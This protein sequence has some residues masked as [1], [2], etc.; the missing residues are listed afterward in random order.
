MCE[1]VKESLLSCVI[2]YLQSISVRW[3]FLS[4]AG[5][6]DKSHLMRQIEKYVSFPFTISPLL[7][8]V[9]V[10]L[11]HKDIVFL[12]INVRYA[13]IYTSRVSNFLHYT[14]FMYFRS[15][16]QVLHFHPS[17]S[18]PWSLLWFSFFIFDGCRHLPTIHALN[19]S[20]S[21]MGLKLI[22]RYQL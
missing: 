11:P 14:P 16:E 7:C 17:E 2:H 9:G 4:R 3:G 6:W 21:L 8:Q 5:L 13:D 12:K 15:Q 18:R 1:W 10:I 19:T 20:G 22:T